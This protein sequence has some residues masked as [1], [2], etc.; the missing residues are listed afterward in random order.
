[1]TLL[2]YGANG[3]TGELIA[4][5]AAAQGLDVVLA[6]RDGDAVAALAGTLGLPHRVFPLDNPAVIAEGIRNAKAVLNCAG[7]FSRTAAPLVDACLRERINYVDITGE[8]SVLEGLSKRDAEAR[9]A[10]V[11]LLPGAGFDVVPSDCLAAYVARK[12]PSA[13]RLTLGLLPGT[14][15]SRG[16]ALTLMEIAE[17][18]SLIRRDGDL[19]RVSSRGRSRRIDFGA[20]P[21]KSITI[22]FG[23]VATAYHT[24]GIGNIEVFVALPFGRRLGM[25]LSRWLVPILTSRAAIRRLLERRILKLPPGPSLEDRTKRVS[26]LWAEASDGNGTT[27]RA[28]LKTPEAYEFTSWLA[29]DLGKQAALGALP[30]GFQTPGRVC[31]LD[32]V[33]RFPGVTL[34]DC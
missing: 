29:V 10:N 33:L 24:T 23:D 32:Y 17:G 34:A 31:D 8:I 4:R 16:S 26:H 2:I 18:G 21:L 15:L 28:R 30:V 9:A 14:T 25:R 5:R 1:M 27:V 20:G 3:Y 11:T 12:V 6:S 13:T 19:V 22:P 7:P